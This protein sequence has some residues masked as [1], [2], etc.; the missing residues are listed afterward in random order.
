MQHL[1]RKKIYPFSG[2]R[3]AEIVFDAQA[4]QKKSKDG[5]ATSSEGVI[6]RGS[7]ALWFVMNFGTF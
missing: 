4:L 1:K 7:L 2:K 3:H 6:F 5:V